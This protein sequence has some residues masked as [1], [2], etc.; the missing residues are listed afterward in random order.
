MNV[1]PYRVTETDSLCKKVKAGAICE[2]AVDEEHILTQLARIESGIQTLQNNIDTPSAAVLLDMLVAVGEIK[3][4]VML[5][6]AVRS[7]LFPEEGA[8]SAAP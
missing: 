3:K 7:K 2:V 6:K 1:R 4:L 5:V 8:S